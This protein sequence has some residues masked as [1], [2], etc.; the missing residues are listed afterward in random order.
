MGFLKVTSLVKKHYVTQG[1][2]PHYSFPTK[3]DTY[4]R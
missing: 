1:T 3:I 4:L 2:K